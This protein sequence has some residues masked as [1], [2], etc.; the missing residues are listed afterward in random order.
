MNRK[1]QTLYQ[2]EILS[3]KWPRG[4]LKK[5]ME[6]VCDPHVTKISKNNNFIC[7]L[8]VRKSSWLLRIISQLFQR[9]NLHYSLSTCIRVRGCISY[10]CCYC[11]NIINHCLPCIGSLSSET[12]I[13]ILRK[14]FA[15]TMP[16]RRK[17]RLNLL[18]K[19]CYAL[20]CFI[21]GNSLL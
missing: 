14:T 11:F 10:L 3:L 4:L 15:L 12:M 16:L 8:T 7:G 18:F 19:T 5:T 20:S 6:Y 13:E 1:N 2:E 17:T 21:K 9:L